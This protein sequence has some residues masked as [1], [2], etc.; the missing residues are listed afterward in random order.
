MS[1]GGDSGSLLLNSSNHF[2]VG[3]LF[4]G[5]GEITV[6][7]KISNVMNALNISFPGFT[8]LPS[9]EAQL[10][11]PKLVF[12]IAFGLS[13]TMVALGGDKNGFK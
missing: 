7:N 9:E 1:A 3:L 12:P 4:A 10:A 6:H 11:F 2:A 13:G 8:P 5:S